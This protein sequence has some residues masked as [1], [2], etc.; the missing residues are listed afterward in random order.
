MKHFLS[1]TFSIC[2]ATFGFAQ[3][4]KIDLGEIH[5]NFDLRSQYYT[6]DSAIGAPDVPENLLFNGFANLNYHRGNFYAGVRYETYQNVMLGYSSDYVG[7]GIVNRYIQ[8]NDGQLDLTVGNFYEQFGNGQ[9]LRAYYEPAL[10][11]DNSIDGARIKYN[12]KGIYLKGLIGKQRWYFDEGPGIVRGGD[13]EFNINE[14]NENLLPSHTR[15]SIGANVVSKYQEDEN[16]DLVLP[17]NTLAYGA[18]AQLKHKCFLAKGEYT[19]KY[20]DP[21]A[22]NSYIYK[23]GQM[24]QVTT[25]YSTK[26]FG[27]TLSAH[28]LDNMFFRSDRN[29]SSIYQDLFI[30]YIPALTKQHTYNLMSTLYPYATQPRGEIAFQADVI[31]TLKR[32][33]KLGGKYGTTINVNYSYAANVDTTSLNDLDGERIGYTANLFKVGKRSDGTTDQY[34]GDFNIEVS[35]KLS[36]R[37]KLKVVYQNLL[38]RKEIIQGKPDE[39]NVYA[40]VGVIDLLTK[41]DRKNSIR[42]EVQGLFTDQDKGDWATVLIEYMHSPNWFVSIMDQYNYGNPHS[43]EKYHYPYLTFGYIKDA[44]RFTLSYGRQREGIFC[45]GGVCRVVPASNGVT[46]SVTS[47]F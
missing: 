21:S 11:I 18:R 33:S 13:V 15:I 22:D 41:I 29:N 31:Y 6:P 14:I 17:E 1:L 24:L 30:N 25:G 5:G 35:R 8:Y 28:T 9:I 38:Y 39:G 27:V 3:E 32:G 44:T 2:L 7:S 20:N 34:F 10:G 19:Y 37:Y 36:K 43:G 23:D 16:V 47:S 26:G 4:K 42:V 40:D 46:L 45:V 12:H